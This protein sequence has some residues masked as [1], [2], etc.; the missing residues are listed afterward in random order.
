MDHSSEG[1]P[2]T[3]A[4]EQRTI[5]SGD[6]AA[7]EAAAD[8]E[9][10]ALDEKLQTLVRIVNR[11]ISHLFLEM[12]EFLGA[13]VEELTGVLRNL[14]NETVQYN[15]LSRQVKILRAELDLVK[16]SVRCPECPF[17]PKEVDPEPEPETGQ[18]M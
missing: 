15:M 12:S 10:V 14:T 2:D 1:N 8:D 3:A 4:S 9:M 6:A 11:H 16:V 7:A 17:Q 18:S 5:P 13:K